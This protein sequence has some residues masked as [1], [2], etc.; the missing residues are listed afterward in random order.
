[1]LAHGSFHD[2]IL[3]LLHY[4]KSIH[5]VTIHIDDSNCVETVT[6][7]DKPPEG[8]KTTYRVCHIDN[9]TSLDKVVN[10][11]HQAIPTCLQQLHLLEQHEEGEKR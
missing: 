11:L 5:P 6:I 2:C 7:A 9:D 4:G 1:M 3:H 8:R 10:L